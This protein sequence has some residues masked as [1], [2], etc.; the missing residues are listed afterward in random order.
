MRPLYDD[1]IK[2]HAPADDAFVAIQRLA[3]KYIV[4]KEWD[5]AATTFRLYTQYF[6]SSK[7]KIN[8]IIDILNDKSEELLIR[9]IGSVINST[10]SEWDPTLTPDGKY[11]YFSADHRQGGNGKSDIWFSE[12]IDGNWSKPKNLGKNINQNREETVDNVTL[13]GTTLILSG[14]FEGTFGKFDIYLAEKDSLGWSNLI[15]L[16]KPINSQYHEESANISSDGNVLIFTSDRPG[17]MGPH[18]PINSIFYHGSTMGNMDIYVCFKTDSGWTEPKNMGDIINTPYAERSV[19]LH[20]DGRTL[21]FSSNGHPGLGGLDVFKSSRLDD[22]WLNWSEPVNLG[23]EINGAEEDWGYVVDVRGDSAL[24]SK[25]DGSVGF[26]G[27]DI[28]SIKLPDYGKPSDLVIIRGKV[29]D[30]KGNPLTALIRWEDLKNNIM[31]GSVKSDPIDGSYIITLTSNQLVGYYADKKNYY[32]S[33]KNLDLNKLNIK[34]DFTENIILY[35]NKEIID[36]HSKILINNIFFD[37]DKS[38]LKNESFPELQRLITFLRININSKII[39]EGHSDNV[40]TKEY[41]KKLSFDRASSVSNYL[42]KNGIEVNRIKVIGYGSTRPL[43]D[44]DDEDSRSKN[45][46]V[47]FTLE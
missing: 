6:P 4:R 7:I 34:N 46:R 12:L 36:D 41:N 24:F 8:K 47:E 44:N 14:D 43:K 15:H 11:L 23:K 13:D 16:G 35:S 2:K 26:G 10:R 37:F 9:N 39:I 38:E 20:P 28:Y 29:T 22:S 17:G 45:R 30:S 1:F 18:V 25:E 42:K 21:Y 27:W 5:S 33:S 19:F 31:L 3:H 32:P 40:G